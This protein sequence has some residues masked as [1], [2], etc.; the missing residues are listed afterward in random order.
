[1]DAYLPKP[2]GQALAAIGLLYILSKVFSY[3]RVLASLF[4]LPGIP[5]RSMQWTCG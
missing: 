1:M 5:V 2:A 4:I 3:I